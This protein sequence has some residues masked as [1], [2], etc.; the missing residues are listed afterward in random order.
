MHELRIPTTKP[1]IT[2][3]EARK[4]LGKES[5]ELNDYQ[6][7]EIIG[8]LSLIAQSTIQKSRS[9]KLYGGIIEL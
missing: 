7:Q 6:V 5:R 3:K 8:L 9:N 1:L 4:L 2:V